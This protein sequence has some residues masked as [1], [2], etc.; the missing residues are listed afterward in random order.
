[1]RWWLCDHRAGDF[2]SDTLLTEKPF[3]GICEHGVSSGNFK[4][5][6]LVSISQLA[7]VPWTAHHNV[8]YLSVIWALMNVL[9]S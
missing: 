3:F 8:G 1:L 6:T 9:V 4:C 2:V 7:A 5:G